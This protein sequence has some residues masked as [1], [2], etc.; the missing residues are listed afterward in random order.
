[1]VVR[2]TQPEFPLTV[3]FADGSTLE[4]KT[5]DDIATELEWFDSEDCPEEAT[6]RDRLGRRVL[7]L[8]EALKVVR[9]ELAE[10]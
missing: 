7:L 2:D 3:S 5:V 6:V 9:N 1:M 10:R 8:V 4:L